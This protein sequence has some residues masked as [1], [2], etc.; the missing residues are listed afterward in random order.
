MISREQLVNRSLRKL[1]VIGAGQ[2]ASA[3][4][5]AVV[6]EVV[7]PIMDDLG[8][9]SIYFWGDP[10][11]IDD[12]SSEHLAEILANSCAKDFGKAPDENVRLLAERRL[13]ELNVQMLSGQNQTTDYF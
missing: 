10:D 2:A 9:R 6:N 1:G 3:E 12:A 11:Q 4:D 8:T 5:F 13:R 7:Q